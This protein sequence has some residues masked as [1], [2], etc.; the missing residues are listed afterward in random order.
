MAL[1]V[2]SVL[3]SAL[4]L[5]SSAVADMMR[6]TLRHGKMGLLARLMNWL[7]SWIM[8]ATGV[9]AMAM[10]Y[11]GQHVV[12]VAA[13]TTVVACCAL[14]RWG[15]RG[16]RGGEAT[17]RLG[18]GRG[19]TVNAG[20]TVPPTGHDMHSAL[21]SAFMQ[22]YL[23]ISFAAFHFSRASSS[24]K[25]A[26]AQAP[27]PGTNAGQRAI[28]WLAA[29][30]SAG[31]T[32]L[33]TVMPLWALV[34]IAWNVVPRLLRGSVALVAPPWASLAVAVAVASLYLRERA[35]RVAAEKEAV[36]ISASASP[37]AVERAKRRLASYPSA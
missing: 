15:T 27:Q 31:V 35:A 16:G 9:P 10:T 12:E 5:D 18:P 33:V 36:R 34:M 37:A 25:A 23:L 26:Q 6:L 29:G 24:G 13:G 3:A 1:S 22:L 19:N 14:V 7:V 28:G 17:A 20:H 11:Q 32:L 2:L 8:L 21:L 30:M 4:W